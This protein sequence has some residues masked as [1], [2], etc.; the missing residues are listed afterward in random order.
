MRDYKPLVVVTE[1]GQIKNA[2]APFIKKRM[3]ERNVYVH[4]EPIP[5]RHDKE[6]RA[7]SIRGRMAVRGIYLPAQAEWLAAFRSEV[8]GFPAVKFDDQVDCLSLLGQVLVKLSP[9]SPP[10]AEKTRPKI[11]STDPSLCSVTLRDLFESNER[12]HRKRA[13]IY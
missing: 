11:I 6:I 1:S 3:L 8:L 7:Q 13:R 5:A 4:V 12:K 2:L 9:G 10:P